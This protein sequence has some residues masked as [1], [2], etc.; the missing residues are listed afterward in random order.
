MPAV[1]TPSDPQGTDRYSDQHTGGTDVFH[2]QFRNVDSPSY[3][4]TH[5]DIFKCLEWYEANGS[6][7]E[8]AAATREL[9]FVN[10]NIK[11]TFNSGPLRE[12]KSRIANKF[13]AFEKPAGITS[14]TIKVFSPINGT[15]TSKNENPLGIPLET[16]KLENK[17]TAYNAV[18]NAYKI[19]LRRTHLWAKTTE[20]ST[21]ENVTVKSTNTDKS[22]TSAD[23]PEIRRSQIQ[24]I[25]FSG[26][27]AVTHTGNFSSDYSI[28]G[29]GIVTQIFTDT[30]TQGQLDFDNY[31]ITGYNA[32]SV[33]GE[34]SDDENEYS[35]DYEN[36]SGA[37]LVWSIEPRTNDMTLNRDYT[38]DPEFASGHA[39]QYKVININE[40]ESKYDITALEHTPVK[41]DNLGE[42][43]PGE[44]ESDTVP[45][46][47]PENPS[48][49]QDSTENPNPGVKGAC[50]VE[51]TRLQTRILALGNWTH[52][53][54]VGNLQF[55]KGM[56]MPPNPNSAQIK[57]YNKFYAAYPDY[58]RGGIN[59]GE[60]QKYGRQCYNDETEDYCDSL[61]NDIYVSKFYAD[62]KCADIDCKSPTEPT[63]I[64][65]KP[66]LP[67]EEDDELE[68]N[69]INLNFKIAADFTSISHFKGEDT[70]K[71]K[72]KMFTDEEA[73]NKNLMGVQGA[74][75][76]VALGKYYDHLGCI[77]LSPSC[78]DRNLE[79][80]DCY[81]EQ[82]AEKVRQYGS[83]F[84]ICKTAVFEG[85]T[86]NDSFKSLTD[87]ECSKAKNKS[88]NKIDVGNKPIAPVDAW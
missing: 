9:E 73:Y 42:D 49:E 54:A 28:G 74:S 72:L 18:F 51:D 61:A 25:Y 76:E 86:L 19:G 53:T 13:I 46:G 29:S 50:C 83:N 20:K 21:V 34:L 80:D 11:E 45:G 30:Q 85:S 26:F 63:E 44:E 7:D 8:K 33:I 38:L 47:P 77:N 37:D 27:Q 82:Y 78:S 36:I 62:E 84:V 23:V 66:N 24:T 3:G 10:K 4:R 39:Q 32:A 81:T 14:L 16:L 22:L 70:N 56:M 60:S 12:D 65:V 68:T 35:S 15:S 59:D 5:G 48:M 43:D 88:K 2:G 52:A 41:Y 79:S 69:F 64:E 31:V 58:V 87:D 75:K 55:R 1:E 67:K 17:N 71:Y 6:A 57:E 40:N